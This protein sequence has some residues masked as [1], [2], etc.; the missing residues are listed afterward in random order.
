MVA[1]FFN[2]DFQKLV[3]FLE[4]VVSQSI[5]SGLEEIYYI[6]TYLQFP[7]STLGKCLIIIAKILRS[8]PTFDAFA[9]FSQCNFFPEQKVVW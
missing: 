9:S 3:R 4:L 2:P 1:V 6:F 5:K 7:S 8:P